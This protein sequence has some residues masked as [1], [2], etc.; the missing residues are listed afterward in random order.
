MKSENEFL[1]AIKTRNNNLIGE[2]YERFL[3]K[4]I[5]FVVKN[6]GHEDDAR[7]IFNKAIFQLS[8]RLEKT[9]FTM[10]SSFEG[11]LFT[12]CK[13]L[14][15]RELNRRKHRRVTSSNVKEL[16]YEQKDMTQ[17][18]LEQER[19][20]LFKE[21]LEKI[22]DNCKQVLQ[23]FFAKK[24]GKDI[25]ETLGYASETVVRQRVFRCK[26]QLANLIK[27]DSRFIELQSI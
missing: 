12:A 22:T 19:W 26:S 11:Y 1:N 18:L 8:A 23:L 3:P 10:K 13:N 15:R 7:D 4:V 20:E 25:M 24:S 14:W 5:G 21:M 27:K 6:S 2:I 9:D 17:S 16:Y